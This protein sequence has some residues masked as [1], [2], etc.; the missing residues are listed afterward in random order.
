MLQL[1]RHLNV[2]LC[3]VVEH[4]HR[5]DVLVAA[6]DRV[7]EVH[8]LDCDHCGRNLRRVLLLLRESLLGCQLLLPLAR[9]V[10]GVREGD[11]RHVVFRLGHQSEIVGAAVRGDEQVRI[12]TGHLRFED[13]DRRSLLAGTI[14]RGRDVPSHRVADVGLADDLFAGFELDHAHAQGRADYRG[15]SGPKGVHH[16]AI[17]TGRRCV[18]LSP[19]A[20][21]DARGFER[22]WRQRHVGFWSKVFRHGSTWSARLTAR[23]FETPQLS[24]EVVR[25]YER[26]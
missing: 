24:G 1:R 9:V 17:G 18:F 26:G 6:T 25:Q 8:L 20:L 11:A 13:D 5:P 3:T 10:P 22:R 4:P 21:A 14:H 16:A 23:I 2:G 15:E 7:I 12:E 19:P